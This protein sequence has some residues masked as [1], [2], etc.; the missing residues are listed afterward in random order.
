M[1]DAGPFLE[2]LVA[3]EDSEGGWG[4]FAGQ[5]AHLE[6]TC[7]ALLALSGNPDRFRTAIQRGLTILQQSARADGSYALLRGRAK[8]IWPTALVLFTKVALGVP[9]EEILRVAARLLQISGIVPDDPLTYELHDF[10]A[11]IPGWGWAEGN[12]SWVEP[13]AWACLALR[14]AGFSGHPRVRDGLRLLLDRAYDDGG[15]NYGNRKIFGKLLEPVPGPT[16][17]MLLALQGVGLTDDDQLYIPASKNDPPPA[18]PH[19]RIA[20]SLR[21]LSAQVEEANLEH[22]AWIKLALQPYQ[23]QPEADAALAGLN[24]RIRN[25]HEQRAGFA[26]SRPAPMLEALTALAL[27][28]QGLTAFSLPQE[29][30]RT[31]PARLDRA[32]TIGL[33]ARLRQL[34]E[35]VKSYFRGI[36]VNAAAAVRPL[37]VRSVVHIAAADDYHDHLVDVLAG[38]F[39]SFRELVPL[40]GKRVVL[41]PNLVEYHADRVINTHPQVVRAAIELCRREGAAEVVVA[42]GP[43]HRRNVEFLLEACGLGQVLRDLKVPF[44]DLNHDEPAQCLNLGRTTGLEYLYL[45]RTAVEADVL[46][47]MAKLKTHH[48]AGATL[49]LKNLFGIV[50]GICY[51]WPKNEL[52]W[53][54]IDR[55]IVDI[56]LTRT[57]QLAIV[58]GIVGMEG[59]G[60]LYGTPKNLGALIMGN[61]P[62]AVDATC[63]RLMKLEPDKIGYLRLAEHK[64]LGRLTA[65]EIEQVGASIESLAQAFEPPPNLDR[66]SEQRAVLAL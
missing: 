1:S 46:I 52:H 51:G 15:I 64:R 16:A 48:W 53:R 2:T 56:A 55:S 11:R 35:R 38:Q 66:L 19:P 41:K 58:D 34:I 63:C 21:Y 9:E 32:P 29:G 20:A 6:P 47:S 17:L 54:G 18:R 3:Q 57:P 25:T 45:A 33:L 44:I 62:L 39:Q 4:Y 27:S 60:P 65:N 26:W 36:F 37:P 12:F 7:F 59:D 49:S 61:D 50:P 28:D 10:D 42:E 31:V 5:P 30:A 40:A 22:L 8:A 43:G 13:T 23:G 24:E 14:R